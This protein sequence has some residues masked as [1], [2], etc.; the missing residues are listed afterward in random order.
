M[1][2]SKRLLGLLLLLTGAVLAYVL[3]QSTQSDPEREEAMA[4]V[5]RQSARLAAQ[6]RLLSADS[7]FHLGDYR[8]ALQAYEEL[9]GN[10]S[11]RAQLG[12]LPA[13][14]NHAR[15]LLRVQ[16]AMDSLQIRASRGVLTVSRPIDRDPV[17]T[18]VRSMPIEESRP[19]QYDS[20]TF[21]LQK[22]ELQIRNLQGQLRRSSG[23]NYLTFE[24]R[25]GNAV[26]YVGDVRD[27]KATG[28]GVA[29]LSSGS[30]YQGEWKNNQ[31]HGFG[32]FHWPDGA[33]YEG[34]F[35]EDE[36]SGEGTYHF[37]GG[38]VFVGEWDDDLRNGEGIFYG[39]DGEVVAQ[40]EWVDDELVEE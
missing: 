19:E 27:G 6:A 34:E 23:G 2:T 18:S 9:E 1:L 24:S 25:E 20:L 16:A 28:R 40:G 37:P 13:R 39:A 32:E 21:A 33:Y 14:V 22:A 5:E 31:K 10:D 12:N 15:Q 35:E 8:S 17:P 3:Y 36:R 7:L 29:L 38:E 4:L 11:L 30:R 26:Y